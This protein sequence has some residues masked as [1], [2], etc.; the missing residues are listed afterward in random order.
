MQVPNT[1]AAIHLPMLSEAQAGS[2]APVSPVAAELAQWPQP[3]RAR[4]RMV[5]Y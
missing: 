1:L 5:A 2:G 3:Q 4:P